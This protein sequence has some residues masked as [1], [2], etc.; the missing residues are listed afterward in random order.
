M[1][2][3]NF[4]GGSG[5]EQDPKSLIKIGNSHMFWNSNSWQIINSP[6][7][8]NFEEYG[9][10]SLEEIP[11][12]A[13]SQLYNYGEIE[14]IT[15]HEHPVNYN[16]HYIGIETDLNLKSL[17]FDQIEISR[18]KVVE[19]GDINSI[20]SSQKLSAFGDI[21]FIFSFDNGR[22]WE[23]YN[24]GWKYININN[25]QDVKENAIESHNLDWI[26]REELQSKIGSDGLL[27]GY[28]LDEPP[29]ET[30]VSEL[31]TVETKQNVA[32]STPQLRDLA[33]YILNTVSTINVKFVGG[34]LSGQIHDADKGKVQYRIK[35]NGQYIYPVQ[36]SDNF[37]DL[38][39][40]PL[41]INF[42]IPDRLIQFDRDNS[43]SIEFRDYWGK[44]ETWETEFYGTYYGL[45]FRDPNGE[46]YS[47]NVGEVLKY[48]DIGT[49][50]AGQVTE[51]YQIFMQNDHG[52]D[53]ENPII[54][55]DVEHDGVVVELS[56]ANDPFVARDTLRWNGTRLKSG[57]SVPFYV[58]IA[59]DIRA[60]PAVGKTFE[61]R[62][63]AQRVK[64]EED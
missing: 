32:N 42:T 1:A 61:I 62:V 21:K 48:L 59:T 11:Q 53:V 45:I 23:S 60:K 41:D 55:A 3:G 56:K 18:D 57:E 10:I 9:H 17:P 58:R 37:T 51:V 63:Q 22:R 26:S 19:Y 5:T 31:L 46:R 35:L 7:E 34:N 39:A 43:L 54:T 27:I 25:K 40:S 16:Y 29:F 28:Y 47:T 24:N 33:L 38:Q 15:Y 14:I 12:E 50:T 4:A 2:N 64:D 49:I 44:I 52:Y 36:G 8:E 13:W 6:T 30:N 20:L